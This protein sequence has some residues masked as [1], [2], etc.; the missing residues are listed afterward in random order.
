MPELSVIRHAAI[1]AQA[2][3]FGAVALAAAPL[4]F[5]AAC[6]DS[7][8]IEFGETSQGTTFTQFEDACAL[9]MEGSS[10]SMVLMV[11]F[12][13]D[14]VL[15]SFRAD[16]VLVDMESDTA[17]FGY[18]ISRQ[19]G[20]V[21]E[22][23]RNEIEVNVSDNMQMFNAVVPTWIVSEMATLDNILFAWEGL[24]VNM[25]APQQGWDEEAA[26]LS[27]CVGRPLSEVGTEW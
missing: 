19:D 9:R 18:L 5:V 17:R 21:T 7:G 4:L 14:R 8:P 12:D 13:G 11:P 2:R 15:L 20:S 27:A 16:T 6:S 22:L 3:S 10:G 25:V 24:V 23:T 1:Q 26:M